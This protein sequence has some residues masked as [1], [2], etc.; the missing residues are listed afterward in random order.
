MQAEEH[1]RV[2]E[3]R[4]LVHA[5][6]RLDR[7]RLREPRERLV[8]HEELRPA[9]HA[10]GERQA[11]HLAARQELDLRCLLTPQHEVAQNLRDGGSRVVVAAQQR[12]RRGKRLDHRE[13]VEKRV[14][15]IL[16]DPAERV[17]RLRAAER[18]ARK[19][20]A[21]VGH[22]AAV[23]RAPAQRDHLHDRGLADTRWAHDRVDAP[24]PELQERVAHL[25]D[26]HVLRA[27][28][29]GADRRSGG[30]RLVEVL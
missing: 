13:V 16:L 3:I 10:D 20:Q 23:V 19:V 25:E 4:V 30:R 5:A 22:V 14:L 2:L 1:A 9:H 17:A 21:V 24:R 26:L 15:R 8:G 28:E 27:Q 6:D 12:Q 11:L 18:V 7:V 29:H